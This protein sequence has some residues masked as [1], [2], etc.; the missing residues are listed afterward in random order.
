MKRTRGTL[1][2]VSAPSGAGKSTLIRALMERRPGLAFSVSYTTR[3]PRPG[4]VDGRDYTFVDGPTFRSMIAAGEFLEWAEVHGAY[5]GTSRARVIEALDRGTSI[6]LDIDVQGA[7]KVKDALLRGVFIF[8]LPPSLAALAERLRSRKA[9]TPDEIARR[10]A[11]AQGEIA[12]YSSYDY[13][14]INDIL[15][16]ALVEFEAVITAA[17]LGPRAIDPDWIAGL[18]PHG[19]A[20]TAGG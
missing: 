20:Q 1:F 8:I 18:L 14:I 17:G 2:V 4:E 15:G 11:A 7:L 6:I 9:N 16:Q 10:T 12:Y 5:Y 19:G 3:P 13:V